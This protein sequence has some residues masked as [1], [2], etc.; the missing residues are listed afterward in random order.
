MRP[1]TRILPLVLVGA[2]AFSACGGDDSKDS[3][4]P[5][6]TAAADSGATGSSAPAGDT[7][8]ANDASRDE[9]A[10]ALEAAGVDNADRWAGEIVEYRPYSAGDEAR[11][12]EELAKY[13]PTDETIDQIISVLSFS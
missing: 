9:I 4:S 7:V 8:S 12:R 6:T 3:S 1:P 13:G 11:L 5:T 2:L 10:A